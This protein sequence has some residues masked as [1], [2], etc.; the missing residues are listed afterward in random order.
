MGFPTFLLCSVMFWL[1]FWVAHLPIHSVSFSISLIRSCVTSQVMHR[2]LLANVEVQTTVQSLRWIGDK[3]SGGDLGSPPNWR[4]RHCLVLPTQLVG[5]ITLPPPT[6]GLYGAGGRTPFSSGGRTLFHLWSPF[7]L[8]FDGALVFEL[9]F[10]SI[11]SCYLILLWPC[12][13]GL[14][15]LLFGR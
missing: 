7:S 13:I 5:D 8:S 4:W 9:G 3:R 10:S 2:W 14:V 15:H 12:H 1:S 11:Y 6:G